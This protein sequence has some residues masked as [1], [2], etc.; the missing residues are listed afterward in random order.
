[1][2]L[3]KDIEKTVLN[4]LLFS[5][6]TNT[7][8]IWFQLILQTEFCVNYRFRVNYEFAFQYF[9]TECLKPEKREK[10]TRDV[11]QT[12]RLETLS[13]SDKLNLTLIIL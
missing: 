3:I 13:D 9:E 5:V 12:V 6:S 10:Y 11:L 7:S 8:Q 1:M 2:P 4:L